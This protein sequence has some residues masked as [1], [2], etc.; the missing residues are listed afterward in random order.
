MKF[1]IVIKASIIIS[2]L[3]MAQ[4][5][6]V[7]QMVPTFFPHFQPYSSNPIIKFGDGFTDA[8]WN[9]PCVMKQNGQYIMYITAA[10]GISGT[11]PVKVYRQIS[12]DGYNWTLSPTTPVLEPVPSTYYAGGTETPSVVFKDG[13][14]H[15]YLT[16][17]PPGNIPSDFVIAHA[18]SSNGINWTMDA[19]PVLQSDGSA[20]IYGNLVGEPGAIV[21]HDSI[22]VFFTSAGTVSGS[23]VQCIGLMKSKDGTTFTSPQQA[24]T[25]PID[26]YPLASNYWGL[27]TP[28]ALAIN[29]SIYLFTDVAQ[30]INGKWTQV[31]LHQFKTDGISGNWYHDTIP[32]HTQ[33]DFNWTNGTLYSEIGSITPLMDDNGL[34]RIWYAGHHLADI[35]G[36]DTTYHVIYDSL[37]HSH[38][39]PN[40][41]G[42]GTS[43]Y[44]FSITSTNVSQWSTGNDNIQL[45]PNPASA[46]LTIKSSIDLKMATINVTDITG[47]ILKSMTNVNERFLK[48]D[49]DEI[50]NGIYFVNITVDNRHWTEK[51][52]INK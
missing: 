44:Q 15:M 20:T 17:Y 52:I 29:D 27:S 21:Y 18:T 36:V 12:T 5:T 51:F 28:S 37:G 22:Y 26:V 34:L 50:T 8:A 14:Y 25:L 31:A 42:I 10:I 41:W 19:A 1:K 32:I 33:Q 45:Y 35:S 9:D 43:N 23:P 47:R 16:C 2:L 24:V 7:A 40:Y 39:D 48:L 4:L 11:T 46:F 30:T 13:T 49:I 38:I 6:T 3:C